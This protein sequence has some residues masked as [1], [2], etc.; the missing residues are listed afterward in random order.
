M[1]GKEKETEKRCK[2]RSKQVGFVDPLHLNS[3]MMNK[4]K[5]PY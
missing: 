2:K 3:E 4:R 5:V 1:K